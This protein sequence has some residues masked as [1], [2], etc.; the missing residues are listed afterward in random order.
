MKD[1]IN[2]LEINSLNKI[3]ETYTEAEMN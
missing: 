1:K 3:S 2:E